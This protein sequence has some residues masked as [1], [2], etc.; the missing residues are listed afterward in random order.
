V[1]RDGQRLR[2][3]AQLIDASSDA[4]LWAETFDRTAGDLFAVQTEIA[5]HGADLTID[6]YRRETWPT[7]ATHPVPDPR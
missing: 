5:E 1:Q 7:P 2:I 4:H 6:P 3:Q